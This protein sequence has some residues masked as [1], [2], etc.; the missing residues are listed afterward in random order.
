MPDEISGYTWIVPLE[1]LKS[2]KRFIMEINGNEIAFFMVGDDIFAVSN[3][4]PHQHSPLI[5]DGMLEGHIVTCPMHGWGFD[6]R[7]GNAVNASG[8]LPCYEV[9]IIDRDVYIKTPELHCD[10]SWF[11]IDAHDTE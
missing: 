11:G 3:I 2:Q 7:N 4:C 5:A 8:F 10:P 6:I 9:K 1:K